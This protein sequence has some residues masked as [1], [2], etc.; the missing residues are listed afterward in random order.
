VTKSSKK[1]RNIVSFTLQEL[2]EGREKKIVSDI[3]KRGIPP[4]NILKVQREIIQ[5]YRQ[6]LPLD[7]A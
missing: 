2:V 5:N 1:I 3:N 4:K 6:V 7:K